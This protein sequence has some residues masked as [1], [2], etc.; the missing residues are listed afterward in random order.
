MNQRYGSSFIVHL[1]GPG[2]VIFFGF[3][4]YRSSVMHFVHGGLGLRIGLVAA[5]AILCLLT[6]WLYLRSGIPQYEITDEALVVVRPWS[7]TVVPW[8]E[9]RHI[10]WKFAIH[11]IVIRGGNGVIAFISTDH[12]PRMLDFL[13]EVREKSG[14][15]LS[16]RLEALLDEDA[17]ATGRN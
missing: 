10:D 6:L 16:P 8:Q 7:R 3:M 4:A 2:I 14:C 17:K 11:A 9:V 1:L 12:F 5:C 15:S 13:H